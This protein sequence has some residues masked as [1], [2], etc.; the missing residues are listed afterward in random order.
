MQGVAHNLGAALIYPVTRTGSIALFI[1][2]NAHESALYV[3]IVGRAHPILPPN[4]P[5][6]SYTACLQVKNGGIYSKA[7]LPLAQPVQ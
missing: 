1:I 4:A 7:R 5:T 6:C 3:S 2:P